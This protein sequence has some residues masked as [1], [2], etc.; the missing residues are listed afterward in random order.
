MV[1]SSRSSVPL[2][3]IAAQAGATLWYQV[4][5]SDPAARTQIQDAMDARCRAICVT[6]GGT[7]IG[8][9][10]SHRRESIGRSSQLANVEGAGD[11]EGHATP[12]A[13]KLAHRED[14]IVVNHGG[15][16]GCG[17]RH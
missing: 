11:R 7:P 1:V 9:A 12:E 13:A 17:P 2:Q 10:A 6:V 3:E 14:G 5:A 16:A 4:F 15:L 8:G